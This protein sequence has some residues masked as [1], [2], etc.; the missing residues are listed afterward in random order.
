MRNDSELKGFENGTDHGSDWNGIGTGSI[1]IL[2]AKMY[3]STRF[4]DF[5]MLSHPLV[6]PDP[7]VHGCF[8]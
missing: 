8:P 3:P 2:A 1:I 5:V 4:A 7:L 6:K